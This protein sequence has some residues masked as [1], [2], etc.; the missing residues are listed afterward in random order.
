MIV[1]DFKEF[2]AGLEYSVK[3]AENYSNFYPVL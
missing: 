1:Q 3:N 2:L